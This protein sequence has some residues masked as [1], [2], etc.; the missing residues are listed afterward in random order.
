M[1]F[2]IAS[3]PKSGNTWLRALI[4]AYYYSKDGVFNQNILKNIGQFPEKKYLTGFNHNPNE[5]GDTA[6]FWIKAQEKINEDKKIRFFK[7]HNIFG[8]VNNS[9]FSNKQNSA[10][11]IYIVR[12]P[13]NVITSIKNHYELDDN[14]ALKWMINPKKF[15]YDVERVEQYGY[16]DFQFISSWSMNNKSWRVQKE[17]PIKIIRY[18]DLLK[19][20]YNV[21]KDV[22]EFI[23]KTL[24]IKD[25]INKEKLKNSVRST[26]FDKLKNDEKNNGFV[27]AVPSK[28]SKEKIPFFNL[29]PDNDWKKILDKDQQIKLT[30][31]FQGDLIE[32]GYK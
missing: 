7:T 24:H 30:D 26:F 5:V 14:E 9:K 1:I 17:I 19:E 31:M 10:G 27:E 15:I 28:I 13:R 29:G 3:Y 4:S 12:D 18:E 6:K 23:N 16:S 32:L 2:W 20:T 25:K 21:F 22:I 11:C 8:A